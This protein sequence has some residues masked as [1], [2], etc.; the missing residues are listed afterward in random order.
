MPSVVPTI[1]IAERATLQHWV[2]AFGLEL[3]A[4]HPEHG[5]AVEH[6]ELRLGDGWVMAGTLRDGDI[7]KP[8][9]SASCYWILEDPVQIDAVHDRAVAA[10]ATSMMAP[11]DPGY[12]GRACSLADRESNLWSFGTYAPAAP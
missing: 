12:G 1:R 4:V 10:G 5:D 3:H 2:D 7:G 8:P 9:G 11:H 6:A